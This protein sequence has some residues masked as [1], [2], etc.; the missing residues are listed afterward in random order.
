MGTHIYECRE[1]KC[2]A[3]ESYA[4]HPMTGICYV[5]GYEEPMLGGK[6][7]WTALYMVAAVALLVAA[8]LVGTELQS[9]RMENE[10]LRHEVQTL[11]EV[12]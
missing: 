12:N 9:L 7:G 10:S 8:V 11:K 6:R 5:C 4:V 2:V 1:G 3:C